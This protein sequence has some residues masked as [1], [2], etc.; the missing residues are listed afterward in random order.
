M[1]AKRP[2]CKRNFLKHFS[3]ALV[4]CLG[5]RHAFGQAIQTKLGGQFSLFANSDFSAWIQQGNAN[6]HITNGEVIVDQ[7]SG[8]IINKFP[9]RDFVLDVDYWASES[10]QASLFFKCTNPY[11]LNTKTAYQLSLTDKPGSP[12][13]AGS[14][15]NIYPLKDSPLATGWNNLTIKVMGQQINVLLNNKLVIS[16]LVD[17]Q[18][19]QGQI[20]ILVD[21]GVFKI[22]AVN[23]VIPGRW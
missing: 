3:A 21:R 10:A 15:V 13:P 16:N 19:A 17:T 2:I 4:M 20:A 22:R 11:L 12:Y 1:S 7:G 8:Y 6:W 18:F 23:V 14:L 5:G 9:L